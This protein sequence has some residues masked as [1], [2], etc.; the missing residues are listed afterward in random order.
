[1]FIIILPNELPSITVWLT[2]RIFSPWWSTQIALS[3]EA[4]ELPIFSLIDQLTNL[5]NWLDS[6]E[7]FLWL[8]LLNIIYQKYV[9]LQYIFTSFRP[10]S[11]KKET[12]LPPVRIIWSDKIGTK[13]NLIILSYYPAGIF[14]TQ[15]NITNSNIRWMGYFFPWLH[16]PTTI[17]CMFTP[18]SSS[19]TQCPDSL[20]IKVNLKLQNT[21]DFSPQQLLKT[22]IFEATNFRYFFGAIHFSRFFTIWV[23]RG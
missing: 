8:I 9:N 21:D 18:N 23:L 7:L 1:M 19:F 16:T 2:L 14:T 13:I 17:S 6:L 4:I 5:F 12:Y 22:Y 15:C 3:L 20:K 11:N 10:N